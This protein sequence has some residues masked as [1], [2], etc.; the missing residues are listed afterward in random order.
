MQPALRGPPRSANVRMLRRA[1]SRLTHRS[2][3]QCSKVQCSKVQCL[4]AQ[5]LKVQRSKVQCSE[6]AN[7]R[8]GAFPPTGGFADEATG[9]ESAE[10]SE[11]LNGIDAGGEDD[12]I[13]RDGLEANGVD[14][15]PIWTSSG[16]M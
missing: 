11:N 5:L 13:D 12:V 15:V 1:I 7:P 2:K 9:L 16:L 6:V 3:V 4:N 14:D 10:G 8:S